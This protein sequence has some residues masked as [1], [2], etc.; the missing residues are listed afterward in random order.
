M[1]LN[2]GFN[3]TFL[4]EHPIPFPKL[5]EDIAQRA[6]EGGKVFPFT[7]FSIVILKIFW[8]K[9]ITFYLRQPKDSTF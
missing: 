6:V 8:I 7:H 2:E 3:V 4:G 5:R 9:I 1:G